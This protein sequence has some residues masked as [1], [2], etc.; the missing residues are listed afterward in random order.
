MSLE[1]SA[2]LQTRIDIVLLDREIEKSKMSVSKLGDWSSYVLK[3]LVE[4]FG[5]FFISWMAREEIQY[6]RKHIL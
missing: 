2:F 4:E 1:T 3:Q 6:I 5:S